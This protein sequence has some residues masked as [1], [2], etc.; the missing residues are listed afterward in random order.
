M[1]IPFISYNINYQSPGNIWP[2]TDTEITFAFFTDRS[3]PC[4]QINPV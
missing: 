1:P 2:L 3:F 4:C